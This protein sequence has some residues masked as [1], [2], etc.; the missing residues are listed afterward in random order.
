[1]Y[2]GRPN[3]FFR[4]FIWTMCTGTYFSRTYVASE[5]LVCTR[6]IFCYCVWASGLEICTMKL[7]SDLLFYWSISSWYPSSY[8]V[9]W[10]REGNTEMWILNEPY[11][12]RKFQMKLLEKS[13]FQNVSY[14]GLQMNKS[15]KIK[16]SDWIAWQKKL[17][18][19]H[20]C[21]CFR[22]TVKVQTGKFTNSVIF[23]FCLIFWHMNICRVKYIAEIHLCSPLMGFN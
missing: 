22:V 3:I 20:L 14:P 15:D 9:I 6:F 19:E 1:M 4:C 23:M 5:L 16:L 2:G 18:Q 17:F 7:I 13:C 11:D 12:W 21:T 8:C 10:N